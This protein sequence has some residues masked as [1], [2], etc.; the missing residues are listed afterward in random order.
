MMAPMLPRATKGDATRTAIVGAALELA[1]GV[2]LEAVSLGVLATTL[3]LSKSGLFAHFGSKEAL[4][5]AVM[6]EAVE[7]FAERVVAPAL[8]QPR[9]EPRVRALFEHQLEWIEHSGFGSG[10]FFSALAN[11]YDDQPGPVRDRVVQQQAEWRGVIARAVS[12]AV[13][14][15]HFRKAVDPA[16]FAFEFVGLT[17]AYMQSHQL[18]RDPRGRALAGRAFDRLVADAR[19]G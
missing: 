15:G 13:R 17:Q 9:G 1:A 6:D 19:R 18:L 5:L 14:E 11:E 2:G 3:G 8:R 10:C 12:L 4:Q 7:R 16:Q